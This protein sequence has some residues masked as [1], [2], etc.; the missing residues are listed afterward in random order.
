MISLLACLFVP[1][2]R[3]FPHLGP[4]MKIKSSLPPMR[5]LLSLIELFVMSSRPQ[6]I[7][8]VV[9]IVHISEL[10]QPAIHKVWFPVFH[11]NHRQSSWR[12][13]WIHRAITTRFTH[14]A[15]I[16][17]NIILCSETGDAELGI[18]APLPY[19]FLL[20]D[21]IH[22]YHLDSIFHRPDKEGEMSVL[23][24]FSPFIKQP[25]W[26]FYLVVSGLFSSRSTISVK[27]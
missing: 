11:R 26:A 5:G 25:I 9:W 21:S 15:L 22:F 12:F 19:F 18:L 6:T 23:S 17:I 24:L 7:D 27:R 16:N 4:F 2:K 3:T 14:M 1:E 13:S 10:S 8:K 20:E